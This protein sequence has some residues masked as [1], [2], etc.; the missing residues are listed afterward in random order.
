MASAHGSLL[1]SSGRKTAGCQCVG[2]R[3]RRGWNFVICFRERQA[4]EVA[5]AVAWQVGLVV[6]SVCFEIVGEY[7]KSRIFLGGVYALVCVC[8]HTHS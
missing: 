3:D 2:D 8:V 1:V 7:C 4:E 5:E 6:K